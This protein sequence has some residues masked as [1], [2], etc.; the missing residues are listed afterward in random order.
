[1][2][3][4]EDPRNTPDAS[5][6]PAVLCL[7]DHMLGNM[8]IHYSRTRIIHSRQG[9]EDILEIVN[10]EK[11]LDNGIKMVYLLA[12]R[13]DVSQPPG[14]VVRAVEKLLDGLAKIQPRILIV[15]GAILGGP[16]DSMYI[17]NNLEEINVRLA[18]LANRDHHWLFFNPN[19]S[20]S[21]AGE[22]QK[23]FFDKE[24]RVNKPGCRFIAQGLVS[25]SKAARLLQKYHVLPPRE[26]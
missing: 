16:A 2:N 9:F 14:S 3:K 10:E 22:V 15:I 25:T 19:L 4:K 13:A 5:K 20:I 24:E 7:L 18:D 1:M 12:G 6:N 8:I 23:R 17:R 21:V 11:L 26:R